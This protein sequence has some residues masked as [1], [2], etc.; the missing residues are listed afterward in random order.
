VEIRTNDQFH[1]L[2][3][4]EGQ[5]IRVETQQ[6]LTMRFSYA[7]TFVVPAAAGAYRLINEGGGEALVVKAFVKGGGAR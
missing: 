2:N 3:L 6:G 5:A 4:V 7:E 1:V